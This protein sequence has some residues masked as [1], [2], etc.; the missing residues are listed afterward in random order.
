MTATD[1]SLLIVED[2]P[3]LAGYLASTLGEKGFLVHT[4]SDRAG[5]VACLESVTRFGLVLLDLGLPPAPSTM[6]EGLALLDE[7][8]AKSPTMKVV[9]LTGQDE[10]VAALEA[11]RRGAFDF[12]VKP[13]SIGTIVQALRRAALF[14][15]EESR[16]AEA[17]ETR[18]HLTARLNEG[19]KEAAAA[20]EEQLL[21]RAL[22]E[23]GYNVAEAARRLGLAREH[24][25]YYLNKYGIR[26]PG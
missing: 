26:R 23:A 5:A 18:V 19:P 13:A 4:A 21:R 25:Y 3:A 22:V 9:V 24:V 17:G 12:L 20:A 10:S 7:I 8:L 11:V 16:M 6:D 15:R 14:M 2:D 1:H